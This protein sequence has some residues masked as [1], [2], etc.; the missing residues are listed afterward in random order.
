MFVQPPVRFHHTA[1]AATE[2]YISSKER[3]DLRER[4]LVFDQ[5]FGSTGNALIC[6]VFALKKAP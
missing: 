5:S 3:Y 6:P 1:V 2:S 4:F